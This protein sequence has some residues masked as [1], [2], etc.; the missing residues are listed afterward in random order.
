MK[1]IDFC[2]Q[3]RNVI[4]AALNRKRLEETENGYESYLCTKEESVEAALEAFDAVVQEAEK[5]RVSGLAMERIMQRH[6]LI[7]GQDYKLQEY[8]RTV[9]EIEQEERDEQE[10][11]CPVKVVK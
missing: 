11:N 9:A 2:N 7:L 3:R 6:G 5:L 10:K 8:V 4:E 1:F